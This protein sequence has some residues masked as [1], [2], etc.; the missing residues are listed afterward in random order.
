MLSY[1][2]EITERLVS[3]WPPMD[4]EN[5]DATRTSVSYTNIPGRLRRQR[6]WV[7]WRV[8]EGEVVYY[9]PRN[10]EIADST[11]PNTWGSCYQAHTA[12]LREYDGVAYVFGEDEPY[13][14]VYIVD[15]VGYSAVSE[16]TWLVME[17]FNS[18][19]ELTHDGCGVL[20]LVEAS[21]PEGIFFGDNVEL[22]NAGFCPISTN[23]V[24]N[25]PRTIKRRQPS[26]NQMLEE[27]G[28]DIDSYVNDANLVAEMATTVA[29]EPAFPALN[30]SLDHSPR[31]DSAQAE[32]RDPSHAGT[33]GTIDLR[34][35][36]TPAGTTEILA[37]QPPS[38]KASVNGHN[39]HQQTVEAAASGEI[40]PNSQPP[41]TSSGT[42]PHP[43]TSSGTD[44]N[45]S[46]GS[47][48]NF[49]PNPTDVA[50]HD[51]PTEEQKAIREVYDLAVTYLNWKKLAGRT[52]ATDLRSFLVVLQIMSA[53][54]SLTTPLS[55]RQLA[56][57]AGVSRRTA[58][59]ILRRLCE[60]GL[61]K[62]V[63]KQGRRAKVYQ[64]MSARYI[65]Q[66]LAAYL[67]AE[68]KAPI[69]AEILLKYAGHDAFLH[70]AKI[71]NHTLGPTALEVLAAVIAVAEQ[72]PNKGLNFAEIARRTGMSAGTAAKKARALQALGLL[73]IQKEGRSQI[74]R[75][76]RLSDWEKQLAEQ[77]ERLSTA[78]KIR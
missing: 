17:H 73:S 75:F 36:S 77:S 53:A 19:T 8:E 72:E 45:P 70:G 7:V 34:V 74:V 51:D 13:I 1:Q 56:Q 66:K 6:R 69:G 41:S 50:D 21:L 26:V 18:Y 35:D 46:A 65:Q 32:V 3:V 16:Q 37:V 78:R 42:A 58:A 14:G 40:K 44:S 43:S 49:T 48:P 10:D 24:A 15:G 30:G 25:M 11:D 59:K 54:N 9:D 39:R 23:R 31:I 64:L 57:M 4:S 63:G 38:V 12:Y 28:I 52:R 47:G 55:T 60:Y 29:T 27:F 33:H 20:I 5:Q 2:S 62:Q 76:V 22:I 61:L 68:A 71:P 67:S